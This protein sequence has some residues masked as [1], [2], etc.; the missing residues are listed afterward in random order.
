MITASASC[1]EDECR[2]SREFECDEGSVRQTR[3]LG[4][5]TDW[6]LSILWPITDDVG[7]IEEMWPQIPLEEKKGGVEVE[8]GVLARLSMGI[9][10]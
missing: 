6:S 8:G 5:K 1:I 2:G 4:K 3:Q 9:V 10:S 7:C